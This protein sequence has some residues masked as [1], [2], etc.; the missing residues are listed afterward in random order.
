MPKLLKR[1]HAPGHLRD[2][3]LAAFEAWTSWEGTGLEPTVEYEVNYT[4][5]EIPISRVCKLVW[6][7]TDVVPG[8]VFQALLDA[9]L[10]M[11]SRTYAACARAIVQ[12]IERECA[13][14]LVERNIVVPLPPQR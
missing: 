13:R 3:A 6:N 8:D 10:G 2:S 11:K 9:G 12:A 14:R 1:G 4:P 5:R 7:C